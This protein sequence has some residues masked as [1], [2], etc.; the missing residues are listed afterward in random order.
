MSPAPSSAA[1]V[2]G[3]Q[4]RRTEN[5]NICSYVRRPAAQPSF[6]RRG[7]FPEDSSR[8]RDESAHEM[9]RPHDGTGPDR[10]AVAREAELPADAAVRALRM[11]VD[12]ADR[13]LLGAAVRA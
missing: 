12:E 4:R 8:L 1:V 3:N 5:E 13:L 2:T 10:G 9:E 11:E 6:H 7:S